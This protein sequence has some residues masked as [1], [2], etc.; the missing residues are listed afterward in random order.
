M[1][2]A[3]ALRWARLGA[4]L[5]QRALAAATG[6]AQPTIARIER[7]VETPRVDTLDRLLRACGEKLEA[8]PQRGQGVDRT[9][10]Q[11]LLR[12]TPAERLR[13]L[14]H[15]A[16]KLVELDAAFSQARAAWQNEEHARRMAG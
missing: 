5:S 9:L 2:A 10:I 14:T 15:E 1:D 11:E 13:R 3:H 16:R 6:V 7:G 4:R 8:Q 12:V